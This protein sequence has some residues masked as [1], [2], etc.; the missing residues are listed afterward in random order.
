MSFAPSCSAEYE[1][2][3]RTIPF[4]IHT[5]ANSG[6]P[7]AAK[8]YQG[9]TTVNVPCGPLGPVLQDIFGSNHQDITFFSLDVEGAER[10]VLDTID[11]ETGPR[12][13]VM[14]IEVVNNYCPLHQFCLVRNQVREKMAAHGYIRHEGLVRA[15]DVYVHPESPYQKQTTS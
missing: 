10:L 13:H 9:R 2:V 1:A 3:N 4:Y 11:F 14:M 6:L 7:G 5:Q 12:I 15:S 8:T